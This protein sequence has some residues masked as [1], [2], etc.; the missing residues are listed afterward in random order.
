M[1]G[2]QYISIKKDV[3]SSKGFN[4]KKNMHAEVPWWR[5][6]PA[7]LFDKMERL[8]LVNWLDVGMHAAL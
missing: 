3:T 1:L 7:S 4:F 6:Q 5:K 2:L 8:S